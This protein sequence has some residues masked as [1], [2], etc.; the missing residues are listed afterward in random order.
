MITRFFL[1]TGLTFLLAACG[2][3]PDKP[4]PV[5]TSTPEVVPEVEVIEEVVVEPKPKVKLEEEEVVLRVIEVDDNPDQFLGASLSMVNET[6]G[7]PIF[8]RRDGQIEVWQYRREWKEG[9]CHLD[10]FLYPVSTTIGTD[11]KVKF[12]DLRSQF[13][14]EDEQRACFAEMLRD[15]MRH[16]NPQ[17]S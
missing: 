14:T 5:T 6:I 13:L 4:A 11:I 12:T 9:V 2:G 1:F 16:S 3:Q 8:A 15:H 17:T 10:L 7:A